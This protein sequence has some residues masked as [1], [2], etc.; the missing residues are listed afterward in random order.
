MCIAIWGYYP[1]PSTGSHNDGN[2]AT[3]PVTAEVWVE[4]SIW[5]QDPGFIRAAAG[6]ITALQILP[7]SA[8]LIGGRSVTI[9]N[10]PGRVY[11]DMKFP[12]APYGMK[13]AC[14]ENPKRVYGTNFKVSP[15]TRMG[16]VAGY[17]QA[18]A[19]AQD[20]QEQWA[21]Y[22]REYAKGDDVSPPK[23][24]LE[25]ETLVGVLEGEILVNMHCYRADD[26]GYTAR[27]DERVWL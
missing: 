18:F 26:M 21:K 7:G 27:H 3:Q 14:G 17:R 1:S 10:V 25:L 16:N 13:M 24:D 12:G 2:E 23:R 4:H 9:K 19:N 15:Q 22:E 6:G 20:Y 8:N 11:Q 5:P